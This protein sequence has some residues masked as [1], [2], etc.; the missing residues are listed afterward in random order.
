MRHLVF[1]LTLCCGW[2]V[3]QGPDFERFDTTGL[4]DSGRDLSRMVGS[5]RRG[6][7]AGAV[8]IQRRLAAYYRAKGDTERARAAEQRAAAA[9]N[10]GLAPL[11][12]GQ[13]KEADS[14]D[15]PS[16]QPDTPAEAGKP[17]KPAP[18]DEPRGPD[19][20]PPQPAPPPA[21]TAVPPGRY[22]VLRGQT[23][24]TWEFRP[25]G[26]FEHGWALMRGES[27]G[28]ANFEAGTYSMVGPYMTLMVLR[29]S[30]GGRPGPRGNAR[31]LR[32]EVPGSGQDGIVLGGMI[33]EEMP[34]RFYLAFGIGIVCGIF[35]TFIFCALIVG[36]DSEK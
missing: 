27:Q 3:A 24:H 11:P 34:W 28:P 8:R 20:A 23:M 21:E 25:D 6:D 17:P 14:L 2:A 32:V 10:Y 15:I 35:G 19:A 1:A 31:R 4:D 22:F 33:L 26:T 16:Y 13:V 18:P 29:Q 30:G 36:R 5:H 9:P 12:A 7:V